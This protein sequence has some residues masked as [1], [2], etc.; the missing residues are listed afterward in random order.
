MVCNFKYSGQD[1][2]HERRAL[3]QPLV[4]EI[5]KSAMKLLHSCS[6]RIASSLARIEHTV[7]E[8]DGKGERTG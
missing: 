3:I 2:P 8:E 1:G 5:R 6:C 4:K 7:S